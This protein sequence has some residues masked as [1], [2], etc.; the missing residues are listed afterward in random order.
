MITML[1]NNYLSKSHYTQIYNPTHHST[2]DEHF[3]REY[4]STNI[5]TYNNYNLLFYWRNG[6]TWVVG[7]HL[8]SNGLPPAVDNILFGKEDNAGGYIIGADTLVDCYDTITSSAIAN[9]GYHFVCWYDYDTN[10]VKQVVASDNLTFIAFFENENDKCPTVAPTPQYIVT[11]KSKEGIVLQID[12]IEHGKTPSFRGETPFKK[13]TAKYSYLFKGWS[14]DL[15]PITK[16]TTYIA[17]FD[18]VINK[19]IV[20][21][22]NYDNELLQID[23]LN[24]GSLPEYREAVPSKIAND[25]FIYS[26]IDVIWSFQDFSK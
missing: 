17:Q 21:F 11:F 26:F 12:T 9:P 18:S 6:S 20:R 1:K 7:S 14:S 3:Q 4:F 25:D 24:Y 2:T 19:Y 16:N 8:Y 15:C 22:L 10:P 13:P 23:T 5:K